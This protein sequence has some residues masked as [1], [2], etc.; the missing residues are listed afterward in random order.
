MKHW[1]KIAR[2]INHLNKTLALISRWSVLIMLGLGFWN[3]IG[4]YVGVA[5]NKNLSSNLLIEGQW[6]LFSLIFLLGI[7]A[8]LH[9]EKHVK[10]DVLQGKWSYKRKRKIELLGSLFLLLPF[11]IGI[12]TVS[13]EPTIRSWIIN[14]TSP[15]PNGLPRYLIKTLIPIGFLS[16]TLQAI[17]E[18]I[19]TISQ[20]QTIKNTSERKKID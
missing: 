10:I 8:T 12:M 18:V 14:E 1:I 5:I 20:L 9:Y 3:V 11:A 17:S 13:I 7:G 2:K 15:D 4:R 6:Y 19:Q 16:L